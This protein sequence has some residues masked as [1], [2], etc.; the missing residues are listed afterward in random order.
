MCHSGR[1][2]QVQ[3][4]GATPHDSQVCHKQWGDLQCAVLASADTS[5]Q[6]AAGKD[7]TILG[8]A[9]QDE[10]LTTPQASRLTTP[11]CE[12][13]GGSP[14]L[15]GWLLLSGRGSPRLS[16]RGLLSGKWGGRSLGLSL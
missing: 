15:S 1:T 6:V 10:G 5:K 3:G 14:L 7:A 12:G 13:G 9:A 2:L 11:R 4:Q 8:A 16:V